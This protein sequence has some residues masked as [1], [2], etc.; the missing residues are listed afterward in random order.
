VLSQRLKQHR[1]LLIRCNPLDREWIANQLQAELDNCERWQLHRAYSPQSLPLNLLLEAIKRVQSGGNHIFDNYLSATAAIPSG[2]QQIVYEQISDLFLSS[3][4]SYRLILL[5]TDEHPIPI[6]LAR[7]I[8]EYQ[9]PYPTAADITTLFVKYDLEPNQRNLRLAAGLAHEDLRIGLEQARDHPNPANH[10]EHYRNRRLALLGIR[11]EAPPANLEIGGLDRLVAAI[12][13]IKF[14]FSD[15]A[16]QVGL[17]FP[18]GWLLAGVPGTGKTLSARAIA[19]QL[20]YPMLS[21]SIDEIK[22]GGILAMAK[23][24]KIAELCAPCLLYLDEME[25]FF[26]LKEDRQTLGLLLTWLNDKD[27]PVFV[28]GTLNRVED[29]PPEI[30]RAGRFDRVW[31]VPSPDEEARLRLFQ[32]FL[33]PFDDRFHDDLVFNLFDWQR[34]VDATPEFVGAEINQVVCDTISRI[35]SLDMNAEV[36]AAD[37]LETATE[38]KSMFNLN[39]KAVLQIRNSIAGLATSA[40]SGNRTILPPR[41]ID[42]YAPISPTDRH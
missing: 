16:R 21:M 32:L 7:F 33:K 35:K 29:L 30:T 39:T 19:S 26:S 18:R 23:V 4:I 38:F 13:D 41:P 36:T 10:L 15:R 12:E 3:E 14:G 9:W 11:Y 6:A 42:I 40:S 8:H 25:K 5:Q 2:E 24:L 20:G 22:V 31:E 27:F 28:I 17:P 1:I 37:L 34:L